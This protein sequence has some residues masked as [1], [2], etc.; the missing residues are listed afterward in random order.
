MRSSSFDWLLGLLYRKS[1][2]RKNLRPSC[3]RPMF[4][5][6]SGNFDTMP[7]D[8]TKLARKVTVNQPFCLEVYP[9]KAS[10]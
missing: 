7:K 9:Q 6:V 1:K 5:S 2:L 8:H 3:L 10:F 4:V